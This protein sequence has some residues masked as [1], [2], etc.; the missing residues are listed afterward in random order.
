MSRMK[1]ALSSRQAGE[2]AARW[3]ARV[4]D[5]LPHDGEADDE[6]LAQVQHRVNGALTDEHRHLEEDPDAYR[7]FWRE[8]AERLP[9]HPLAR[10]IY[11]D[12]LLLTGDTEGAVEEMLAAFEAE[13]RLIYRMSGEYRDV[14][15]RAGRSE[16]VRYRAL[17][18]RAAELDDPA[19]SSDYVH[20]SVRELMDDIDDDPQL[21]R[22]ALR[23]LR[24]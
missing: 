15:E 10:A 2:P 24:P 14:M 22:E 18:I 9:S 21:R 4:L 3:L 17:T 1:Q 20:D 6:L 19:G 23:I 16:W 12:T 5:A 11:A 7:G 8:A 13:P